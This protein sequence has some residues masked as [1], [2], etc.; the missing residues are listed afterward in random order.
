ML[1]IS[2]GDKE[3]DMV[4][5][6]CKKEGCD[7]TVTFPDSS[8]TPQRSEKGQRLAPVEDRPVECP[9]CGTSYYKHEFTS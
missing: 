8:E 9:K 2:L 6:K 7:G 3:T 5:Y 4:Q 1:N